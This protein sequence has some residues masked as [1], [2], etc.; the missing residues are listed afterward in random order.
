[1]V[2]RTTPYP[3]MTEY[4]FFSTMQWNFYGNI[5]E[6][7]ANSDEFQMTEITHSMFFNQLESETI[8]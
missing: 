8:F 7:K 2:I 3:K 4:T 6:N 5:Y 1:M